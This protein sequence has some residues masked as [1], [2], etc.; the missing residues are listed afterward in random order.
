MAARNGV[1]GCGLTAGGVA[2][3]LDC[4]CDDNRACL[5]LDKHKSV[6]WFLAYAADPRQR[7]AFITTFSRGRGYVL[8][9]A[10][11]RE[12]MPSPC[13]RPS[14]RVNHL[15]RRLA[16]AR[17]RDRRTCREQRFRRREREQV[18]RHVAQVRVGDVAVGVAD[19]HRRTGA[20]AVLASL[21]QLDDLTPRVA[22]AGRRRWGEVGRIDD[23][24]E[25]RA[26]AAED[27]GHERV[28]SANSFVC[29]ECG[30]R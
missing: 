5:T 25:R 28:A 22:G 26:A 18:V 15:N 9:P 12:D 6:A 1:P 13:P 23:R 17:L 4:T 27:R 30:S 16:C 7:R 2:D 29:P 10:P 14:K 20:P 19:R 8:A 24:G 3:N 21:Q 11:P